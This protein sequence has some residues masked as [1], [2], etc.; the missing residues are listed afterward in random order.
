MVRFSLFNLVAV[1]FW[2]ALCANPLHAGLN[3]KLVGSWS[4]EDNFT[5]N[6]S[7]SNDGTGM[8]GIGFTHGKLGRGLDLDGQNDVVRVPYDVSLAPGEADFTV[9]AW[10][11]PNSTGGNHMRI[12]DTR[13]T[14]TSGLVVGWQ[15]VIRKTT[16]GD[17]FYFQATGM[18]DGSGNMR[19][20]D[21]RGKIYPYGNWYHVT[22]VL[23]ADWRAHL[24]VNGRLDS[25]IELHGGYGDLTSGLPVA[26]GGA[27][28]YE[29]VEDPQLPNGGT[30]QNFK[31]RIDEVRIYDRALAEDEV[32]R[33]FL[34]GGTGPVIPQDLTL[35]VPEDY[36][37]IQDAI[38]YLEERTIQASATAT[39]QVADGNYTG[40]GTIFV[41]HPQ[42]KQIQLLG[43]TGD[44]SQVTIT[45]SGAGVSLM[46]DDNLGLM[47]GFTLQ[48]TNQ[49]GNGIDV[50][51]KSSLVLGPEMV[52]KDFDRGLRSV[53]GSF[54]MADG[55]TVQNSA[56]HGMVCDQSST[57]IA[58][59]ASS[60]N[61]GGHGLTTS[62][63]SSTLFT[64]STATNNTSYDIN[65]EYNGTVLASGVTLSG[66]PA[67]NY[68]REVEFSKISGL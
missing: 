41:N 3:D 13:G 32:D 16:A 51:W 38:A 22:M 49:T 67:S 18:D 1:A 64:G 2:A 47:D 31:G 60:S 45:F 24:Y 33:L 53:N 26:I 12:V 55:V 50:L 34:Q 30:H 5:D 43:N 20:S 27:L 11:K 19:I 37:T 36:L 29:G 21:G 10:F 52:I 48:G 7:Y 63:G 62:Y 40:Y 23:N 56:L 8:N 15:I 68:I 54:V 42:G 59:N 25:I 39:I 17:G 9:A 61:N 58:R 57:L 14:G 28:A 4:F 35:H 6:S 46:H 66:A 65:V 44:A